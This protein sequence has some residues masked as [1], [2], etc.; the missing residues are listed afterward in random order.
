MMFQIIN[1]ISYVHLEKIL[2]EFRNIELLV[3]NWQS[4]PFPAEI[5]NI[6]IN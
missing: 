1:K 3:K 4:T 6:E 2:M 5:T